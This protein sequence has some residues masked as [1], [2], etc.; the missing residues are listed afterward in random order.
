MIDDRLTVPEALELALGEGVSV[1]IE[2]DPAAS[3]RLLVATRGDRQASVS[4]EDTFLAE[5][6]EARGTFLT[7]AYRRL[8]EIAAQLRRDLERAP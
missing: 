7:A 5:F 8:E 3:R 1:R 6:V 2:R 4:V